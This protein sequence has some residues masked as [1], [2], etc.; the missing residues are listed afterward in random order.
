MTENYFYND[1]LDNLLCHIGYGVGESDPNLVELL[2][3]GNES[4]TGGLTLI[5]FL[6]GYHVSKDE[7][8][9]A[10]KDATRTSPFLQYIKR[11]SLYMQDGNEKWFNSKRT[12][13]PV[14]DFGK[15][16]QDW[17][18]R[19]THLIDIR[20]LPRTNESQWPYEVFNIN[21]ALYIDAFNTF[22]ANAASPYGEW[23]KR[24]KSHLNQQLA[25]YPNL[26]YIIAPGAIYMKKNFLENCFPFDRPF[27]K[28]DFI[29]NRGK[30]KEFMVNHFTLNGRE[31]KVCICSF[32]NHYLLGLDGLKFMATE[33]FNQP[34]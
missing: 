30:K 32:F 19:N 3:V 31:V 2:I 6:N 24:R 10:S 20:P 26:K 9:D 34:K 8:A 12:F 25:S 7:P 33:I 11:F 28:I 1:I 17:C 16:T 22:N 23:V 15:I 13:N 27:T 14:E 4:G 21:K 5:D 18:G 29:N